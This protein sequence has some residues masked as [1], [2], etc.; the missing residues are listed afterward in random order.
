MRTEIHV[1]ESVQDLNFRWF[2]SPHSP[3]SLLHAVLYVEYEFGRREKV[4][5]SQPLTVKEGK[6]SYSQCWFLFLFLYSTHADSSPSTATSSPTAG[7]VTAI[8]PS[9]SLLQQTRIIR[10]RLRRRQLLLRL[11][12]QAVGGS[13]KSRGERERKRREGIFEERRA[14][15]SDCKMQACSPRDVHQKRRTTTSGQHLHQDHDCR[16]CR[17]FI[18]SSSSQA[19]THSPRSMTLCFFVRIA[20]QCHSA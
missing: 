5:S 14:R 8:L 4:F 20:R 16:V 1:T 7:P 3:S 10:R 19:Y 2:V 9:G 6:H 17:L 18:I 15:N 12:L 13:C 11:P